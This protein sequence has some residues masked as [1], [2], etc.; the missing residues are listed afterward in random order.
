MGRALVNRCAVLV[1]ETAGAGYGI[2]WHAAHEPPQSMP[3]S[4][5]F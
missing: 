2:T 3:V 4:S 5:A 1:T